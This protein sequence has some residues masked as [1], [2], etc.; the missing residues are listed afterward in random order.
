MYEDV[1]EILAVGFLA[2][3]VTIADVP[4]SLRSLNPA[5]FYL[6]RHRCGPAHSVSLWNN[7]LLASAVWMF[8]GQIL[9]EDPNASYE[10]Y[11]V[12]SNL[13]FQ[14]KRT[15][16][17]V[18]KSLMI[19]VNKVVEIT[20]AF[21]YEK[22]S[23]VLWHSLGPRSIEF[24]GVPGAERVGISTP[25]RIWRLFNESEDERERW[26]GDWTR[27][28]LLASTQAP[29]GIKKLNAS[30]DEAL[31]REERRRQ[32]VMDKAY[33]KVVKG[34]DLDIPTGGSGRYQDIRM[35]VTEEELEE[36]MKKVRAGVKDQHD[37]IVDFY[38]RKVR[39]RIEKERAEQRRRV[40]ETERAM[41]KAGVNEPL[42]PMLMSGEEVQQQLSRR[43]IKRVIYGSK[44][45]SLYDKYVK[46]DPIVGQVQ[47]SRDGIPV[48][49]PESGP[50]LQAK[51]AA[52]KPTVRGE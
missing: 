13:P 33:Y 15:L 27:T 40:E 10:V 30:D 46:E 51:V 23:R 37:L 31:Q 26:L 43:Q 38:K 9:L 32:S 22:E 3:P 49:V 47:T 5:D 6:A 12:C 34:I 16:L 20:E 29:K 24:S 18:L 45:D 25:Q 42:R 4:V 35:A 7:W 14:A 44:G 19:R 50:S 48:A 52:R 36:E 21:C 28:K 11:R 2:H 1:H 8:D 41:A 17:S 39:E